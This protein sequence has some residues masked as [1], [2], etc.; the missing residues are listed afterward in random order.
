MHRD[1]RRQRRILY[2]DFTVPVG[3]VYVSID[4]WKRLEGFIVSHAIPFLPLPS[5]TKFPRSLF[6]VCTDTPPEPLL[7]CPH[8]VSFAYHPIREEAA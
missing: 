4:I 8:V 3:E 5:P 6:M 2:A 7:N 1:G